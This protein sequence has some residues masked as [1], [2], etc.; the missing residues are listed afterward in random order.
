[1]KKKG[2]PHFQSR[3]CT[4]VVLFAQLRQ[5]AAVDEHMDR[6][7]VEYIT[8][9]RG[10]LGPNHHNTTKKDIRHTDNYLTNLVSRFSLLFYIQPSQHHTMST[11]NQW[12]HNGQS[13]RSYVGARHSDDDEMK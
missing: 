13:G 8:I 1:M 12:H 2:D 9:S 4:L 10:L 3:N 6:Q 5:S 11:G 7:Y